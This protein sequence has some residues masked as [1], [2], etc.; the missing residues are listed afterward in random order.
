MPAQGRRVPG[1]AG[2]ELDS[3]FPER[4]AALTQPA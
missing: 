2:R 3:R 4:R 1:P